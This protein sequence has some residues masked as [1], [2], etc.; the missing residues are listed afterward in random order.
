MPRFS[1][2]VLTDVEQKVFLILYREERALSTFEIYRLLIA[3]LYFEP[4]DHSRVLTMSK[5]AFDM[6]IKTASK[7]ASVPRYGMIDRILQEASAAGWIMTRPAAGKA[8]VLYFLDADM[9]QKVK[10]ELLSKTIS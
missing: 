10:A 2:F 4:K 9:R 6:G 5:K 8:K 1:K 7:D 3:E